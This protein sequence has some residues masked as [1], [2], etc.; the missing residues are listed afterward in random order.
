M[1]EE[2]LRCLDCQGKF[3]RAIL[4]LR[5][6]VCS[7]LFRVK[8]LLLS[9]QFP[10]AC[11][12]YIEPLVRAAYHRG[13]EFADTARRINSVG[14]ESVFGPKDKQVKFEPGE[15]QPG[16]YPKSRPACK[17]EPGSPP[18]ETTES[19]PSKPLPVEPNTNQQDKKP[20]PSKSPRKSPSKRDTHEEEKEKSRSSGVKAEVRDQE[21]PPLPRRDKKARD[22]ESRS[23][24]RRRTPP[25]TPPRERVR[26]PRRSPRRP[27]S[28]PGPPPPRANPANR[29]QG[30]IPSY[31]HRHRESPP[32]PRHPDANNKGTKKRKQQQLFNEFKAWRKRQRRYWC[33]PR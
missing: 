11:G 1:G 18:K 20:E 15:V 23:A 32:P 12:Q 19:S 28:P 17:P 4:D 21:L 31:R 3:G 8:D 6:N 30:P 14:A 22:R 24:G 13:L 5:C 26:S 29:W 7:S 33:P 16:S 27:R 25:R 9:E 2:A 10:A